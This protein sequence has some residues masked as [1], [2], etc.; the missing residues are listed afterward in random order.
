MVEH[1]SPKSKVWV[2]FPSPLFCSYIKL[3][4][5]YH[6]VDTLIPF[7]RKNRS[8]DFLNLTQFLSQRYGIGQSISSLLCS[9]NGY[10]QNL[11]V[12]KVNRTYIS[13]KL[14]RFFVNH[15]EMMDK[16]LRESYNSKIINFIKLGTYKGF[17]HQMKYPS[18][19][20][21]TRSNARTRRRFNV[22]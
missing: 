22:K 5:R 16:S 11:R 10:H 7:R 15:I 18:N 6:F 19:G 1:W 9:H 2:Q 21:R 8:L 12:S 17:R 14:R 4:M 13:E 20:Q 3:Y